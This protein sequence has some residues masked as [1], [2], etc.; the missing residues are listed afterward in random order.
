MCG[1]NKWYRP[2]LTYDPNTLL[3]RLLRGTKLF[4]NIAGIHAHILT[5]DLLN[6]KQDC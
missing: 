2:I 3:K 1:C 6:G 4:V 5:R